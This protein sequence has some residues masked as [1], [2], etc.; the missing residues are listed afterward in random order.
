MTLS[1]IIPVYNVEKHL[2]RCIES[3]CAVN[4]PNKE[5]LCI[6]DG[7]TDC[8]VD[9]IREYAS[10]NPCIKIHHQQ[11]G[12]AS[13]ARN[14]GIN[15][16]TGNYIFFLDS[17]DY[18]VHPEHLEQILNHVVTNQADIGFFNAIVNGATKYLE[19][20]P[21]CKEVVSGKELMRR[22]YIN[23]R[24]V[25]TPVWMQIYR[26]DYLLSSGIK[27]KEG[28][29]HEDE[30]FTPIALY[31]AGRAI[32]IDMPVVDYQT[33]RKDAVTR[34]IGVKF[35]YDRA[36]IA[37]DLYL[38][39]AKINATEDE[40]YRQV[41]GIYTQLINGLTENKLK[42]NQYMYKEDFYFMCEC[43]RTAHERR[44]AKIA[45][46][47]PRLMYIYYN[48]KLHPIIRKFINHIFK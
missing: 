31:N 30:L 39:F 37:R 34:Q 17:D 47:S 1:I 9:I 23:N 48:N 12:G 16:A 45:S 8:S 22:F 36:N 21:A 10:H 44:C 35:F 27:Q 4:I 7:S 26:R 2:K 20:M 18:I 29:I 40:P 11:H 38:Y 28:S 13:V 32:C 15:I 25:P 46:Y 42:I 24:T 33:T 14:N 3:V 41:F 5:I 43:A 19:T 6:D